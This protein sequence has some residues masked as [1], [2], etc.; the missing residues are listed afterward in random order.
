[1][2]K[3]TL[4][5]LALCSTFLMTGCTPPDN[6]VTDRDTCAKI[7]NCANTKGARAGSQ[8]RNSND[9]FSLMNYPLTSYL[10]ERQI[11]AVELIKLTTG[12]ADPVKTQFKVDRAGM[13][14][15]AN[16]EKVFINHA[17]QITYANYEHDWK[18]NNIKSY[19][20][21]YRLEEG[22]LAFAEISKKGNSKFTTDSTS[23]SKHYVNLFDDTYVL[24][25]SLDAQDANV[26]NVDLNVVGTIAGA[27]GAANK[28][29]PIG[30]KIKMQIDRGS[31]DSDR[32]RIIK[33]T[34]NMTYPGPRNQTFNSDLT[35]EDL[36]VNYSG[37]CSYADGEAQAQAGPKN[38]YRVALSQDKIEVLGK[39]WERELA[40][41]GK[42]PLIDLGRFLNP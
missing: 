42:R 19:E 23:K 2:K 21:V 11:E 15:E 24:M 18:T 41:C 36:I 20:A 26:L 25:V 4:S 22:T 30:L 7:R 27:L 1:M 17:N 33:S 34:A 8:S 35:A 37:L 29:Y 9:G 28:T 32:V 38:S 39:R 6:A 16:V 5:L 31:L 13:D 3:Q 12:S 10:V 40:E 14:K